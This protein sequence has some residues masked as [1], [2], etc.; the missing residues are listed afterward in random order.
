MRPRE[1]ELSFIQQRGTTLRMGRAAGE[2][3]RQPQCAALSSLTAKLCTPQHSAVRGELLRPP[4]PSALA[5]DKARSLSSEDLALW[6]S[7]GAARESGT[8]GS[9]LNEELTDLPKTAVW[10]TKMS[11]GGMPEIR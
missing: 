9:Q 4:P 1:P 6:C 7:R 5:L 11:D 2:L 8:R 10:R 3:L